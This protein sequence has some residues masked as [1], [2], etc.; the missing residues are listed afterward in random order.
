MAKIKVCDAVMGAGK[1]MAAITEMNERTD[2][3]FV[4]VTP[5]LEEVDRIIASCPS[6]MFVEPDADVYGTKL[7]HFK[8]LA[9][10]GRNIACTHALFESYDDEALDE[11]ERNGYTLILDEVLDAVEVL[12]VSER[13]LKMMLDFGVI[14]VDETGRV[15][16]C[17][18]DDSG[19]IL[20]NVREYIKTGYV[21]LRDNKLLLWRL[22]I[23]LFTAF[24]EVIILT[25][26]FDVQ[27]LAYHFE[28]CGIEAHKIGTNLISGTYRFTDNPSPSKINLPPIHIL[29]D[30]KLNKIGD[31]RNALS[32][33]WYQK[34]T[35]VQ[36]KALRNTVYNVIRNVYG[37]KSSQC[38]WTTFAEFQD[39]LKG[40]GYT[41]SF[42]SCSMR[43]TNK[44]SDR[45]YLIYTVNRFMPPPL[46]TY[47]NGIGI[48]VDQ[49]GWALSEMIQWI[50][51][52]AIRKGEEIWI[53]VPSSRMRGLLKDWIAEVSE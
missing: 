34:S 52:S 25:Y 42:A 3:K 10:A 38:L 43:A 12:R 30:K 37:V 44:W 26:M 49:D 50:W 36:R 47:F 5:Y 22:P 21:T 48:S 9:R 41:K 31:K 1:T 14:A 27:V 23:R 46:T 29:E 13:N 8:A 2:K 4:F 53:Y 7:M 45:H 18:D 16:W 6:R 24:Q 51:R 35:S 28:S 19:G 33:G 11:I 20:W 39:D 17:D 32:V 40:K 15:V